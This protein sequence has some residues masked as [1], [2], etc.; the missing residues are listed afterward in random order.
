MFGDYILSMQN[1]GFIAIQRNM[2][3]RPNIKTLEA[4]DLTLPLANQTWGEMG[5]P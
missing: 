2:T 5:V 1:N 4:K 3:Q